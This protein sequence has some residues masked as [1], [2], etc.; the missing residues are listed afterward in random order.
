V[1]PAY[2]RGIGLW[3]PGF[4]DAE[5][6][7]AASRSDDASGPE[8]KLLDGAIR[9][10][11]T[12]LT[13]MA[14]EVLQ[15]AAARGRCDLETVPT[16]WA[17]AHGEH[18]TG[19]ALLEMMHRDEG[20]LSPTRFHNSVY[21]TASGYAS[22]ASGNQAFSTTL[23]GGPEL[24]GTALLEAFCLLHGGAREVIVVLADEP[25]LPPFEQPGV[26]T[27]LAAALCLAA[28]PAGAAARL[29]APRRDGSEGCA[30]RAEFGALY[31]S[32]VLPLV[33]CI[34]AARSERVPLELDLGGKDPVWSTEVTPGSR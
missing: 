24:V 29:E 7:C 22:I 17:S 9:R 21:N 2:V 5:A 1:K 26:R 25:M 31:V 20:R 4:A 16:V 8:A 23:S 34:A 6:W 15:Q 11:A 13:R 33:E 28:D 30:I 14:I 32:A 27:P 3:T 19:V 12:G 18:E 10:R